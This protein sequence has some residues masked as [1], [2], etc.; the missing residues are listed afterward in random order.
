MVSK[1]PVIL[2]QSF[3]EDGLGSPEER[4]GYDSDEEKK[5]VVEGKEELVREKEKQSLKILSLRY[6]AKSIIRTNL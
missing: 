3:R 5:S 1:H 2:S 6:Y 4:E